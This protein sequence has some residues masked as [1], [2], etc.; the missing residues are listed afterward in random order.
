MSYYSN[1]STL[2]DYEIEI[3]NIDENKE[4]F[5]RIKYLT[6]AEFGIPTDFLASNYKFKFNDRMP[7]NLGLHRS[8]FNDLFKIVFLDLSWSHNKSISHHVSLRMASLVAVLV[9][10]SPSY[11][12]SLISP[13]K[14]I[15]LLR[16][17]FSY[18]VS[19]F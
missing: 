17:F 8:L 9:Q 18:S 15:D 6:P 5:Q 3:S 1:L 2:S 14:I 13:A 10:Q 16:N 12:R 19:I 11:F 4:I 7:S